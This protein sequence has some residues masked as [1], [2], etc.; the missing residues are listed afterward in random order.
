M[1]MVDN[2]QQQPILGLHYLVAAIQWLTNKN[3]ITKVT[4][5]HTRAN[6]RKKYVK[7]IPNHNKWDD[8]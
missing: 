7:L 6:D 8:F 5:M 2:S 1:K 4:T 3:L